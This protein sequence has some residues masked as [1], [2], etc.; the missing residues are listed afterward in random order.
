MKA[1]AQ[2]S[3]YATLGIK[4]IAKQNP[5]EGKRPAASVI[6]NGGDLRAVGGK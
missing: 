6:K 3:P 1:K 2:K 5:T 4:R